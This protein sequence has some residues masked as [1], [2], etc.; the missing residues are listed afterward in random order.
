MANA[1]PGPSRS[2]DSCEWGD[3]KCEYDCNNP[4]HVMRNWKCEYDCDNPEHV[5]RKIKEDPSWARLGW[6]FHEDRNCYE[7]PEAKRFE[8]YNGQE[9]WDAFVD[10]VHNTENWIKD[11]EIDPDY[12]SLDRNIKRKIRFI[13]SAYKWKRFVNAYAHLTS[14]LSMKH[15]RGKSMYNFSVLGA[16]TLA[17]CSPNFPPD[18]PRQR[19]QECS[20]EYHWSPWG[21]WGQCDRQC[22]SAG[23]QGKRTR[24]RKCEDH[25]RCSDNPTPPKGACKPSRGGW[26]DT[27]TAPCSPCPSILVGWADW[28]E[29]SAPDTDKCGAKQY[30]SRRCNDD[31]RFSLEEGDQKTCKGSQRQSRTLK[32]SP[33]WKNKCSPTLP[34]N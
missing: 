22:G 6:T 1:S 16:C 34:D 11:G 2:S 29:W 9:N 15:P 4:E 26:K 7:V 3:W 30:R 21:A 24:S 18:F 33:Y 20:P 10:S 17:F 8:K 23:G 19:V 31:F 5:M 13:G 27:D 28:G 32:D 25:A 12:R 14:K